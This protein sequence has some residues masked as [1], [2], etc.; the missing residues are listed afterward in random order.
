MHVLIS[1]SRA[2]VLPDY[3][4]TVILGELLVYVGTFVA[5]CQIPHHVCEA[6]VMC[7]IWCHTDPFQHSFLAE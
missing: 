6:G 1:V 5:F 3:R 2:G 7:M 4:T